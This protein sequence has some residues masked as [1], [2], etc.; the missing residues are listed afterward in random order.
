MIDLNSIDLKSLTVK[1]V[2]ITDTIPVK[3]AG[4]YIITSIPRKPP[5]PILKPTT[6]KKQLKTK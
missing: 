1:E 2:R 5:R 3:K 4:T 6:N